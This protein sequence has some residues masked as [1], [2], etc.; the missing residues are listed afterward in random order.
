MMAMWGE[1]GKPPNQSQRRQLIGSTTKHENI[2]T[3]HIVIKLNTLEK[4][5][6]ISPNSFERLESPT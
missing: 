4:F 5:K 3:V 6:K 2:Q 1:A